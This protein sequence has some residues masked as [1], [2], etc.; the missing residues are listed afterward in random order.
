MEVERETT[1]G[2]ATGL[3]SVLRVN[4]RDPT[5]ASPGTHSAT[6]GI[7]IYTLEKMDHSSERPNDLRNKLRSLSKG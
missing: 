3:S 7:T 4:K 5:Q 1:L 6:G 2:R